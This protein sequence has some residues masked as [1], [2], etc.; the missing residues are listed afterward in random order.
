MISLALLRSLLL[1]SSHFTN[2]FFLLMP[3]KKKKNLLKRCVQTQLSQWQ[4]HHYW[5]IQRTATPKYQIAQGQQLTAKWDIWKELPERA[6]VRYALWY[7]V[8]IQT[9]DI[10]Y[11]S[12]QLASLCRSF[13]I[14]NPLVWERKIFVSTWSLPPTSSKLIGNA[15]IPSSQACE[16]NQNWLQVSKLEIS[17]QHQSNTLKKQRPGAELVTANRWDFASSI[18]K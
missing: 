17:E 4:Q 16:I 3:F 1:Y 8:Y 10:F 9:E 6:F 14:L 12:R 13:F 11:G 15:F 2:L 7:T 5:N 18:I